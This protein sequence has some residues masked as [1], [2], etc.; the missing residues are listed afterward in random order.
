MIQLTR[1]IRFSLASP[2]EIG[3]VTNSWSGWP[4]TNR[5]APFL[6]LTCTVTGDPDRSTGY[7]CNIKL[8]D[9]LLRDIVLHQLIPAYDGTQTAEQLLAHVYELAIAKWQHAA[10][11]T[12]LRLATS[13]FLY[14]N[15]DSANPH[16]ICLTQQFEF[17]ASHRLH[18][19]DLSAH[20]NQELFGKCNNP[21]GHGHNYV[22]EVTVAR[23][24]D[25][26]A[27]QVIHLGQL[28]SNVKRLVVDRLDHKHLNEDVEYFRNVIPSVE[29]ITIAIWNWLDGELGEAELKKV[30][31]YETPKTWAEYRGE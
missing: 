1:E 29:N 15:I 13:P 10:R 21:N 18:C 16:M 5:I 20:D 22:V 4:S 3:P 19:S 12:Q 2:D 23:E 27:G 17:S 25:D 24:V 30:R 31:V 7:V 11:I 6:V 26:R 14:F 28:E 9:D 8:L